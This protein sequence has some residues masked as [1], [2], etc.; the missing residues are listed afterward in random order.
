MKDMEKRAKEI[1]DKIDIVNDSI[2][3]S[4]S[5]IERAIESL[6]ELEFL[7]K[8]SKEDRDFYLNEIKTHYIRIKLDKEEL[9]NIEKELSKI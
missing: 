7:G 6:E 4:D 5:K 2:I 8:A 1:S 3:F 9:K